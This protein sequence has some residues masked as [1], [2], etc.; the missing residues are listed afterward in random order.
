[1]AARLVG[2]RPWEA[3]WGAQGTGGA[4]RMRGGGTRASAVAEQ[5]AGGPAPAHEPSLRAARRRRGLRAA[6]RRRGL[7]GVVERRVRRG[8]GSGASAGGQAGAGEA[9]AG[10][11]D[12]VG[13]VMAPSRA[14]GAARLGTL[15]RGKARRSRDVAH[16]PPARSADQAW[17]SPGP[18]QAE[19]RPR[20]TRQASH[21][22]VRLPKRTGQHQARRG[23]LPTRPL[24]SRGRWH[25]NHCRKHRRMALTPP[26]TRRAGTSLWEAF[27]HSKPN[28]AL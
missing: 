21:S 14:T 7:E 1:M 5:A 25:R 26:P 15:E 27:L 6:M 4:A 20:S 24:T 10:K 28:A 18:H 13:G 8:R 2:G 16:R 22:S 17:P 3:F 9:C 12:G 19:G 11:S 23:G